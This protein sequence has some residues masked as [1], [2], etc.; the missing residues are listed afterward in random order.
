MS[1]TM[2]SYF[3]KVDKGGVCKLCNVVV[4]TCGNTT[5]LKQH[6]KRKHPGLNTSISKSA[7]CTKSNTTEVED[8]EDNTLLVQSV[9]SFMI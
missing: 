8:D 4:K 6:L 7:K 9:V 1:S 2:W 5:N 3:N